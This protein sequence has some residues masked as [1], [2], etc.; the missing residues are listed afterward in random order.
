[1][2]YGNDRYTLAQ[3]TKFGTQLEDFVG[4]KLYCLHT[5]ADGDQQ[6]WI[7]VMTLEFFSTVR[8]RQHGI[9][10]NALVSINELN[11]L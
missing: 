5:R 8:W 3:S 11:L 9:V 4:A 2:A 7:R 1:V 6:I 10:C